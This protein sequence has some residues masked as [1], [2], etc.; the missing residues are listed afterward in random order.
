MKNVRERERE[1]V[2]ELVQRVGQFGVS[3]GFVFG[4]TSER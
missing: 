3:L 1:R 2:G 4:E